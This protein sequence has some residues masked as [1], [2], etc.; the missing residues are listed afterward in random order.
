MHNESFCK[1]K[2]GQSFGSSYIR[3]DNPQKSS[4]WLDRK[5]FRRTMLIRRREIRD[6]PFVRQQLTATTSDSLYR[7]KLS[8]IVQNLN[9]IPMSKVFHK[10]KNRTED[11]R[12]RSVT[13]SD[14]ILCSSDDTLQPS[15]KIATVSRGFV[16]GRTLFI[17]V[18]IK[19]IV[20]EENWWTFTI[21]WNPI[22]N[23]I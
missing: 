4:L 17:W 16:Y 15:T 3:N 20:R 21:K 23:T 12:A 22:I 14:E 7:L 18:T 5:L 19:I 10:G 6:S 2:R 13:T 11:G 8:A 9:S 1:L